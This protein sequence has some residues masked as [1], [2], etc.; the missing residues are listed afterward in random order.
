IR[1]SL[2][3]IRYIGLRLQR[4]LHTGVDR[5][6]RC[7]ATDVEPVS[8]LTAEAQ[9]GDGFGYV[10]LAEQIAVGSVAAHAILLRITPTEGAPDPPVAVS[11][12]A[13]R[14][15]G[16]GHLRKDF[17]VRQLSRP[18]IH[19]EHAD[20]RRIVRPIRKAGVD[21]VKLLLVGREGEAVGLDEIVDDNL[22]V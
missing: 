3:P 8:L 4:T 11:A 12:H 17:A 15:A 19:V 9:V 22:D 1:Y 2:L 7:R 13:I 10:D 6:E 16:L 20:M 5:I 14:D 18:M 21:D